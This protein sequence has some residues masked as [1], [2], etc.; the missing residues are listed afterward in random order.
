[1]HLRGKKAEQSHQMIYTNIAKLQKGLPP[2][3][4]KWSRRLNDQRLESSR[5]L[6]SV[7]EFH[8]M[9]SR[10]CQYPLAQLN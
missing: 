9:F 4:K 5:Y 3:C 2:N 8:S 7:G 1:M 6:I 10:I